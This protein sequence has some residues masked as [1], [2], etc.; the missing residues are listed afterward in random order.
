M[1]K[2][3]INDV[4]AAYILEFIGKFYEPWFNYNG[5]FAL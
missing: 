2:C 1:A 3:L 4:I 5:V